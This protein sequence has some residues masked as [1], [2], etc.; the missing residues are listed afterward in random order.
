MF[1]QRPRRPWRRRKVI[2]AVFELSP[3]SHYCV[4][5]ILHGTSSTYRKRVIRRS[6]FVLICL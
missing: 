2:E 4:G 1:D 5:F 6:I 3:L